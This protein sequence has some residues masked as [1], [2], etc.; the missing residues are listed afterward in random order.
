M[1][2]INDKLNRILG[3]EFSWN[4]VFHADS[5]TWISRAL[6]LTGFAIAAY[7]TTVYLKH[8][9]PICASS[10]GCVIVQ[11]SSYA[12]L[13]GVPMPFFGLLGYTALFITALLPGQRARTAGMAFT[14]IAIAASA[15]LTFI[16]LNIIHA[17]CIWCVASAA[18]A[19]LHVI[20][21][22]ARYV[23]GEPVVLERR[24]VVYAES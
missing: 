24:T 17:V 6:S 15:A 9:P 23:R 1:F 7:L 20:V 16:E 10:E 19:L 22:S 12:N 5:L 4:R 3:T 21:N 18:C 8:V 11:H 14:V 13:A 2:R